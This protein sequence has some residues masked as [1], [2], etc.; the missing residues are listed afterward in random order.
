M[1]ICLR[2]QRRRQRQCENC[3][4]RVVTGTRRG[5]KVLLSE[6]EGPSA[7]VCPAI[8]LRGRTA[9]A[10]VPIPRPLS[11]NGIGFVPSNS[12]DLLGPLPPGVALMLDK[13]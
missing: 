4:T 12:L 11:K 10:G 2:S 9:Q 7:L 6:N 5:F 13:S 3:L 1:T 8:T